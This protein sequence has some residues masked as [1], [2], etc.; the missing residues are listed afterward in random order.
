MSAILQRVLQKKD[1]DI[2]LFLPLVLPPNVFG[3][4]H[5]YGVGQADL[6]ELF[7]SQHF[8][9]ASRTAGLFTLHQPFP[10]AS[11][12]EFAHSF[13]VSTMSPGSPRIAVCMPS[14]C[15]MTP[16]G[17]SRSVCWWSNFWATSELSC[18]IAR[19]CASSEEPVTASIRRAIR[20]SAFCD[21]VMRATVVV[22]RGVMP[23][24]M[25]DW[26]KAVEVPTLSGTPIGHVVSLVV[27]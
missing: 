7:L 18:T 6:S 2:V 5:S 22:A 17:P 15:L 16:F 19:R 12:S 26:E 13:I 27:W 3:T 1:R 21:A 14:N 20:V 4:H 24:V 11:V 10:G 9:H 25:T 8:F 23:R